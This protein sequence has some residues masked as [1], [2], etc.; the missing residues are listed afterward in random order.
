MDKEKKIE[1]IRELI[2]RAAAST[3]SEEERRELEAW[4]EAS[5]RNKEVVERLTAQRFTAEEYARYREAL[6]ADDWE[7]ILRKLRQ[8]QRRRFLPWRRVARYAAAVAVGA[9]A[10]YWLN[11]PEE[12]PRMATVAPQEILPG[13]MKAVLRLEDGEQIALGGKDSSRQDERLSI[14]GI[15]ESDSALV[16]GR[17]D[18]VRQVERHTLAIPRG[19]EYVLTLA[20]GSR[21]WLN[22]ESELRFPS[23]F[24]GTERRVSVTG[25]A[26]FQVAKDATAP[27]VVEAGGVAVRVTGTEF[28]VMAYAD[29]ERVETTLAEGGVTVEAGGRTTRVAPGEQAVFDKATGGLSKRR[30]DI[31]LYTSWKSG[32]FEFRDMPLGRVARQ[33][34]RW[35]DVRIHFAAPAVADI[36]FTGAVEKQRPLDFIL[37]IIRETRSVDYRIEGREVT[38]SKK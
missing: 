18:T 36:R 4:G 5:P 21:V 16:Y 32:L 12:S 7:V 14:R 35:Y 34:E 28:N 27:F 9:L 26:Y 23:R 17:R 29:D 13:E 30:V 1:R 37:D 22:S 20:D 15:T 2:L 8:R 38:I 10:L 11:R 24:E 33:L 25:E 3:L 6:A 31:N 19:G